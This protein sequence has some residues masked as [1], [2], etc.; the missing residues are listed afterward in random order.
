MAEAAAAGDLCAA[1]VTMALPTGVVAFL[2]S[3]VEAS[4][5]RWAGDPERM[6]AALRELD[7]L[8]AAASA[9]HRGTVLKARGEGDSHFVV[10]SRPSEAVRAAC[11]LQSATTATPPAGLDLL[12]RIGVH[13][14]EAMPAEDDYYGVAVNQTARLRGAAYGGQTVLSHVTAD[15]ARPGLPS[16]VRVK[17]LGHH[18]IRDFAVLEEVFQAAASGTADVFPPLRTGESSAP[19]VLTVVMIDVCGASRHMAA[20][21]GADVIRWQRE[22]GAAIRRTAEPKEPAGLKL[23]G[24]GCL[25]AFDDPVAAIEFVRDVRA[26]FGANSMQVRC[27]VDVGRVELDDGDVVGAAVYGASE[28]CKKAEP[29]QVLASAT[30][31][32]LAAWSPAVPLGR[33]RL[34]AT[35][36][37]IE[38]VSL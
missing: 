9:H 38:V 37:E 4:G 35:G 25:A 14:G 30:V 26:R 8:V 29:D 36:R 18:R 28:L 1:A 34:R 20:S 22:F 33:T 15:L 21:P 7:A 16:D 10:F 2:M 13:T 6:R 27:G 32:D 23:L 17:S 12:V 24:D 3:D 5:P 31:T 11:E 19:A